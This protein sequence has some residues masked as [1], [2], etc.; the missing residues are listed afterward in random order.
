[1]NSINL[2]ARI[3]VKLTKYGLSVFAEYVNQVGVKVIDDNPEREFQ[4]HEFMYIFGS[5]LYAGNENVI[6]SNSIG[7]VSDVPVVDVDDTMVLVKKRTLIYLI[8]K[9]NDVKRSITC[10]NNYLIGSA[11]GVLYQEMINAIAPLIHMKHKEES[12]V[13]NN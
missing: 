5:H 12:D 1:M 13:S 4:L 3:K 7:L 10:E 2:N 6:E 9:A 11:I 8:D